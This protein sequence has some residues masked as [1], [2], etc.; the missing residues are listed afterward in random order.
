MARPGCT[1]VA[2]LIL[3]TGDAPTQGC[4]IVSSA[5]ACED[6]AESNGT[7]FVRFGGI[8]AVGRGRHS[9]PV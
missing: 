6:A 2:V 9:R 1:E 4:V 7:G 3:R 8:A 5:V